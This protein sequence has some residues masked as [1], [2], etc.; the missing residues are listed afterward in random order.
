ML[1]EPTP[2]P[3]VVVLLQLGNVLQ[4]EGG[5]GNAVRSDVVK[6]GITED[7]R[8]DMVAVG[9]RGAARHGGGGGHGSRWR[10]VGKRRE[11]KK[12]GAIWSIMAYI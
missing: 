10:K 11:R 12:I 5:L 4:R 6:G 8:R 7:W 3:A 9:G 1:P 2:P